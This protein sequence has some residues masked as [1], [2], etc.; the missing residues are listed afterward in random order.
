MR[1]DFDAAAWSTNHESDFKQLIANAR[2]RSD[3]LIRTTIPGAAPYE[4]QQTPPIEQS[5][6]VLVQTNAQKP[7]ALVDLTGTDFKPR[8]E[9]SPGNS[10]GV[11]T[12]PG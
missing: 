11:N 12:L 2:K 6:E 10:Q 9:Q 8:E 7:E 3:A 5:A 4:S 1:K